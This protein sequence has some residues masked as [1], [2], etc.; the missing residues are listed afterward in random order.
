MNATNAHLTPPSTA[1]DRR[2]HRAL[3]L[4][5]FVKPGATIEAPYDPFALLSSIERLFG[6][7]VSANWSP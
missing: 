5:P 2:P 1:A 3:L 6:P 7:Q 4:S